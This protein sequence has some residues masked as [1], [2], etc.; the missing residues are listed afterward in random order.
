MK[1][2]WQSTPLRLTIALVG[3]FSVVSLLSLAVSY[4]VAK[5]TIENTLRETLVADLAGFRAAPSE[6]ALAALV[7]AQGR[8]LDPANRII[9]YRDAAGRMHGN[10]TIVRTEA[11]FEIVALD[12]GEDVAETYFAM[13]EFIRG[14]YLTLAASNDAQKTLRETMTTVLLI[15]LLPTVAI[16][17]GGGLLIGRRSAK[18]IRALEGTLGLLTSGDLTARVPKMPGW[19]GDLAQI[20]E[21]IDLLARAQEE[22]VAALRQVTADI[23]HDLKTPIQRVSLLLDQ[24]RRASG[25]DARALIESAENETKTIAEIFAALLQIAQLEGR[26]ARTK[27]VDVSLSE[28]AGDMVELYQPAAEESQCILTIDA[29]D[30]VPIKGDRTLL[31]QLMANLIENAIRYGGPEIQVVVEG[32]TFAVIDNGEGIPDDERDLVMRRLYRREA[33]RTTTGS[34]LGLAIVKAISDLH[35]AELKLE[36]ANPGL[37]VR[38]SFSQ[39]SQT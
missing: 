16:A 34:G 9:G 7:E 22:K 14:G 37:A 24:A 36:D 21:R 15:S 31:G 25:T 32:A 5:S 2:I 33:S 19:A 23:A 3:L 26:A 10:G 30:G 17:L 1:R 13:T 11:G 39:S 6:A 18:R 12:R 38:L 35:G 4:G 8:V 28:L 29:K 20:G 27:F